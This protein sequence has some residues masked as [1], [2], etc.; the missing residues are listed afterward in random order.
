[1][2]SI[3]DH[4]VL[5]YSLCIKECICPRMPL[6]ASYFFNL[7]KNWVSKNNLYDFFKGNYY[8]TVTYN[9]NTLDLRNSG[10]LIL[11]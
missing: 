4:G 10:Y 8:L 3:E 6:L 2:T 5:S 1:M 7:P 11:I 9:K